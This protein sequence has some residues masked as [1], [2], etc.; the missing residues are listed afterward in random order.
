MLFD[1]WIQKP[2]KES[3]D[4]DKSVLTG[5]A[6]MMMDKIDSIIEDA[7]NDDYETAV[8]RIDS[9][10]ERWNIDIEIDCQLLGFIH[11]SCN[12]IQIHILSFISVEL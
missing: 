2:E 6:K 7:K 12:F 1:E 5:K 10:K 8:K 11:L 3:V 9:F 4:I